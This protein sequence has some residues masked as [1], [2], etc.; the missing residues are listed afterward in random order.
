WEYGFGTQDNPVIP[1]MYEVSLAYTAGSVKAA[2]A[3]RDGAPLAFNLSGGLHHAHYAKA[4]GFC[5][6]NDPAVAVDILRER[7]ARVAYIDIDVH[8]GDGVQ[9]MFYDDPTVLTCSIHQDPRTL[10]PGTGRV[11]ETGEAFTS[12]NV[13]LEPGTTGD[14]WLWA[15]ERSVLP[16]LRRFRPEAVVLQ[17]GTD[18]HKLDPLAHI[19]CTAQEWVAAVERIRDF[20]VPIVALGGGGY[21]LATVP[22]MW[23]AACLSLVRHELDG[24]E[25]PEPFAT[26]WEMPL[27]FDPFLPEPRKTGIEQAERVVN[28]LEHNLLPNIPTPP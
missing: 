6:F 25:I 4:S 23:A 20:G 8:H 17:M 12:L 2:E 9:W 14:T 1:G 13:P 3:V 24:P 10:Y 18:A 28:W 15:F 7:F 21:N 16:A 11:D 5:V 19:R 26:D 22:R 27:F